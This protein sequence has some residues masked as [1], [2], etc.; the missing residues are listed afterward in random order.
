MSAKLDEL[1]GKIKEISIVD[2][3]KLEDILLSIIDEIERVSDEIRR[4][5]YRPN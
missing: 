4:G 5:F 1:R 3:T 2:L